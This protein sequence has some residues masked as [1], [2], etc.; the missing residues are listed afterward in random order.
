MRIYYQQQGDKKKVNDLLSY[1]RRWGYEWPEP[2]ENGHHLWSWCGGPELEPMTMY[3][4]GQD[5]DVSGFEC[6]HKTSDRK[7][8]RHMTFFH[9]DCKVQCPVLL[10]LPN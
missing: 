6:V 3:K 10:P 8:P 5:P 4:L 2:M 1:D 9:C 7:C